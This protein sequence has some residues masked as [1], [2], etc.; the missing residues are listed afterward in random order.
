MA[1]PLTILEDGRDGERQKHSRKMKRLRDASCL[2]KRETKQVRD[3]DT[4][5]YLLVQV[6]SLAG[7]RCTKLLTRWRLA[8]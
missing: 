7:R 8:V 4:Q 1:P 6:T 5:K 3:A 2:R